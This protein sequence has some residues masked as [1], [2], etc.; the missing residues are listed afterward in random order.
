[1]NCIKSNQFNIKYINASSKTGHQ[2]ATQQGNI[3]LV[4]YK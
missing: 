4:C 3:L 1:M 2:T